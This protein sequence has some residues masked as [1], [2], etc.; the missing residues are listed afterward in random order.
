MLWSPLLPERFLELIFVR[1]LVDP[2]AIVQLEGLS[3]LKNPVTSLGIE[4]AAFWL[5]AQYTPDCPC[6]NYLVCHLFLCY[7]YLRLLSCRA[8]FTPSIRLSDMN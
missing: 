6:V 2:R 7:F 8:Y 4:P 5:V 1:G 3:Q